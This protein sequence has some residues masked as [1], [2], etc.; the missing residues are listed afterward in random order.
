MPSANR[1]RSQIPACGGCGPDGRGPVNKGHD[2]G[3][4]MTLLYPVLGNFR[5]GRDTRVPAHFLCHGGAAS[6]PCH[7]D[8]ADWL[9]YSSLIRG[10]SWD[11]SACA[12]RANTGIEPALSLGCMGRGWCIILSTTSPSMARGQHRPQGRRGPTIFFGG[13][14][15]ALLIQRSCSAK[16][17]RDPHRRCAVASRSLTPALTARAF[18]NASFHSIQGGRHDQGYPHDP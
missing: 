10:G 2:C 1:I 6:P 7:A 8:C 17:N 12:N 3:D 9:A 15:A 11:R 13:R 16:E 5:A 14:A 4:G 18:E